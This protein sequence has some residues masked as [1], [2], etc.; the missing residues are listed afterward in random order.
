MLLINLLLWMGQILGGHA[1]GGADLP[2]A[3]LFTRAQAN[4]FLLAAMHAEAIKDP[5]RRCL[6]YPDPPGSHWDRDAVEAYCEYRHQ[7]VISLAQVRQYIRCGH[8]AELDHLLAQALRRQLNDPGA[9]APLDRIFQADFRDA[10]PALRKLLNEWKRESPDSA[11]AFAASGLAYNEAAFDA[12]GSDELDNTPRENITAM[13][14][15]SALADT[16]LKKAVSLNPKVMPA[17]SAMANLGGFDKGY[18]YA[19][20][21]VRRGL[22]IEPDNYQIYST[23]IWLEQPNWYG[24]LADMQS[25]TRSAL[26]HA[27]RNPTLK[28]LIPL[29]DFYR[30]DHCHCD[31]ATQ[32]PAYEAALKHLAGVYQ[33]KDA[34]DT[35]VDVHNSPVAAIYTSEVLRFDPDLVNTR[36][37]RM[38]ALTDLGFTPW[39][40]REGDALIA[41]S[42]GNE[43]A[44]KARGW[45]YL[46]EG[47]LAHAR[48]DFQ[49]ATKLAPKDMWAWS[50]LGGIYLV[51]RQWN[52]AW[53][54]S[55]R[56][57]REDPRH[58]DGWLLR[59]A[60]EEHQPRT[61]L[62]STTDYLALQFGKN[63]RVASYVAHLRKALQ[64]QSA[65]KEPVAT[66]GRE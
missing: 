14:T 41:G 60:I 8:A 21:A 35:A 33:L 48:Q 16:D 36:I 1:P 17:W 23:L 50:K 53:D 28:M 65:Q 27:K 55:R 66:R 3:S 30:I 52:D 26:Q 43:Y 4:T 49:R 11:F 20:A 51:Q 24:S 13:D 39:A 9:R 32:L 61:G 57:I 63:P 54:V 34:A 29:K 64:K 38:Y 12:R 45:A 18:E 15:L 7:P 19:D 31:E 44:V 2:Q 25:M 62:R 40:E 6:A 58:V 5:L 56:L 22:A 46:M 37:D 42:P 47:D 59:A 10:S